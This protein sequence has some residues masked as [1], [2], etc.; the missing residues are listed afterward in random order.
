M[1]TLTRSSESFEVVPIAEEHISGFRATL[2]AV[3]RERRY[4]AFLEAP[5]PQECA[6]F[7]RE[8][9]QRQST[10]F[11][12]LIDNQ[13]VGWCDVVPNSRP[14]STHSGVLGIGVLASHRGQGIGTALMAA[15]LRGA[16]QF[17]LTRVELTVRAD[18][19]TA[20]R[21]YERF[22]FVVEGVQRNAFLVDGSYEDLV[23]MAIL[24]SG[25]P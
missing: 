22:G 12:A 9:I 4:L 6:A 7:V 25:Q 14:V 8:H 21:L 20:I 19:T 17:G 16:Q 24:F 5:T 23:C 1:N 10:Q 3:C 11:V 15:A 2:D 18:N 13:V